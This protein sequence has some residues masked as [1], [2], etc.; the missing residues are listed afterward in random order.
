MTTASLSKKEDV[1]KGVE[2]IDLKSQYAHVKDKIDASIMRVLNHG[3][4]IMGPEV[5]TLEN[6]LSAFCGVKHTLGCANGTDA[7]GLAMRALDI[8]EGDAVFVPSFTFAATAETV[9]WFGAIPVYVDVEK[10]TYNM[11]PSSLAT[12]IAY[13]KEKN[14]NAKGIISVDIFGQPADYDEIEAL[15]KQHDL[16]LI[17]DAA[18]SYGATYKGRAVGAI[19]D[20]ATTSFFPAKPLG[21]YGDGGAVFTN[22]TQLHNVMASLRV[23]GQ[24]EDKYDNVRIGVN[25]RLDTLQ[26]A[27][28]IEKLAI[29]A[30]ELKARQKVADRYSHALSDIVDTPI[31]ASGTTSSW[32]QYTI[33]LRDPSQRK[34]LMDHLKERGIPSVVYYI[35]PLHMQKIYAQ[36][37]T[38]GGR[39]P[40]TEGLAK[41]VLSLPMHPYLKE[42]EQDRIIEA[43]RD[44]F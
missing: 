41:S 32:A 20:I 30:D 21:C 40:V 24:G 14:L 11:S 16:W 34:A 13:A 36:Y 27:I 37:H 38:P 33:S 23:H 26:A 17:C 28:L 31:L 19:G 35:N 29:F 42:E 1:K 43:V 3:I 44:F 12:A 6:Q 8:K 5:K 4:Y 9:C 39:L 10:D 15:A 25:S 22:N 7:L 18:Q 2:F